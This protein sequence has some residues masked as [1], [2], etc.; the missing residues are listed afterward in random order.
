MIA[1]VSLSLIAAFLFFVACARC[2]DVRKVEVVVNP[3]CTIDACKALSNNPS[4]L[5]Y[6]KSTG[7]SDTLHIL[8]SSIY[9]FTVMFFKTGLNVNIDV[10]WP[11]LLSD[12]QTRMY[13]SIGFSGAVVDRC[14]YL[15]QTIYEFDD[16]DGSADMAAKSNNL[17]NWRV[18]KTDNLTWSF[19]RNDSNVDHIGSFRG[20]D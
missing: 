6:V 17:S 5:V 7:R 20:L 3:N 16:S 8:Y 18:Y 13:E 19:E 11:D 2:E 1:K 10:N 9:T 12:N 14:G 4:Y 15:L